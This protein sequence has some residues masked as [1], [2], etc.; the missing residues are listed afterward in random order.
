MGYLELDGKR[1]IVT[2]GSSGLGK[3]IARELVA[4][5]ASVVIAARGRQ[6]LLDAADELSVDGNRVT[7]VVCDTRSDDS[8]EQMVTVAVNELGGI[9]VLVNCAASPAGG[10]PAASG[11]LTTAEDLWADMNVKVMGYLRCIRQ[12]APHMASSG[13]GRI[14]NISGLAAR[15]TGSIVG[16]VRNVAV[17]AMTKCLAD[18]LA[19]NGITLVVVHPGY[20]RTERTPDMI[21]ERAARSSVSAAEAER[22]MGSQNLLGRLVDASEVA[23]VVAFL[24]SPRATIINGDAVVVGGGVRGF[25][26]Y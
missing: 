17:A 25:I 14:V 20:T 16:T 8:V 3:A 13:G 19:P 7:G 2:G 6:R 26:Y 11:I 23:S 12:V 18:E 24:A 5:G 22:L 9:D 4:N 15:M 1:A 21:A 10:A